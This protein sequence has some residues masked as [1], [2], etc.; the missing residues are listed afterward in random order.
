MNKPIGKYAKANAEALLRAEA[1]Q[2]MALL[3]IEK[4]FRTESD[5]LRFEEATYDQFMRAWD[6]AKEHGREQEFYDK[7]AQYILPAIQQV[8][9]QVQAQGQQQGQ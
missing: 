1:M 8:M 2:L 3:E 4:D 6:E 5:E 9:G 7:A